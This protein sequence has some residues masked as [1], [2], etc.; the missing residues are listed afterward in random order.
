MK[1]LIAIF[2]VLLLAAPAMAADWSFYGSQRVATFY[3]YDDWGDGQQPGTGDDNDWGIQWDFQGNS[4]LGAKV[5]ADKVVGQI[6]LA[7][8]ATNGG[9]GGDGGVNTR[10]AWGGWKFADNATLKVGKDYTPTSNFIA[11]QVFGG[12]GD[13]LGQGDFYGRRPAG[14]GL[15]LG[16]FE[17]W[18][19]HNTTSF[20][21]APAGAD[22]DWNL[23][24]LEARYTLKLGIGEFIPYGGVQY[25]K[26]SDSSNTRAA[27]T[28]TD[29]ADIYSYVLGLAAKM[30]F[31]A[32]YVNVNGAYGQNWSNANWASGYNPGSGANSQAS[33]KNTT[34]STNDATS[35][36]AGIF[37]GL[38]F[39]DTIKFEAG[40]GYR[41]DDS[42]VNGTDDIDAWTAWGHAVLTL[43][44]GVYLIPEVGYIDKGDTNGAGAAGTQDQGYVWYGGAKWQIDF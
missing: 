21:G 36:V 16:G 30:N 35:W 39:T 42:D 28:L 3:T 11:S 41:N 10:R 22:I 43:A 40:F 5:K 7:L 31:G 18:L 17:M 9:D 2:A 27:G 24:K 44:P 12:D 32:F 23:P 8:T 15:E 38:K 20:T 19:L 29:D 14:L 37:G 34:G 25:F 33:L 13:I 4:R 6:E 1:K 26:L